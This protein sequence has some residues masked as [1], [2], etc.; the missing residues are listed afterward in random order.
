M[1]KLIVILALALLLAGCAAGGPGKAATPPIPETT[2]PT[3]PPNPYGPMDFGG[4]ENAL[5]CLS[6]PYLRGI[7]ISHWQG[8]VDWQQVKA[9]GV[10]FV[11]LRLG[12]RGAEQGLL[13]ADTRAQEYYEGARAAGLKIGAYFFS[14]AVTPE[15][16]VEEAQFARSIMDGWTL[17][18]PLAYDWEQYAQNGRTNQVT[19]DMLTQCTLAFCETVAQAGFTPMVYFNKDQAR[20]IDLLALADYEFWLAMYESEMDY[21]HRINMWQFSAKGSIPGI[22]GDVDMNLYFLY[23]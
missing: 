3:L 12:Q 20:R 17:D 23:E 19:G 9:A 16:A 4:E 21:P 1:I 15:E 8:D 5:V 13:T 22:T 6:G 7:D 18:M 11:I 14:Q 10:E 2:G